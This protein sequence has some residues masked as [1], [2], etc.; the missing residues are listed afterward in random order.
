MNCARNRKLFNRW[1]EPFKVITT[2]RPETVVCE[3]DYGVQQTHH[4]KD[5]TVFDGLPGRKKRKTVYPFGRAKNIIEYPMLPSHDSASKT[6]L[7]PT[8]AT[9]VVCHSL[10]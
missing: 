2:P 7:T 6:P 10:S 4:S 8:S 1:I 5:V 9:Y 3:I